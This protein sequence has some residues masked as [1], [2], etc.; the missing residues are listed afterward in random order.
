M[1]RARWPGAERQVSVMRSIRAALLLFSLLQAWAAGQTLT[2]LHTNDLHARL[3]PLDSGPGGFAR[4][5]A[6]IRRERSGCGDCI[7]LSAGDLVQGS[8]VSTIFKGR[9]VFEIANEFGYDAATLGNHDFDYGWQMTR[10]FIEI[11]HYPIVAA[12]IVDGGG[13]PFT[14]KT[15]V[16]LNVNG[17]RIAV[18]GAMTDR[19]RTLSTPRL[20]GPW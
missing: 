13:H 4:L 5:A 6:I 3:L 1:R 19:L 2:I 17:L 15:N 10:R 12:N 7:L 9:P 20:L 14:P 11:A 16:V 8:P 18:T